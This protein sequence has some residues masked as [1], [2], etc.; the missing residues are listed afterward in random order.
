MTPPKILSAIRDSLNK[1][2][3][4]YFHAV[5][6]SN[7]PF[8]FNL[9]WEYSRG[10]YIEIWLNGDEITINDSH[11]VAMNQFIHGAAEKTIS[12]HD[13]NFEQ[14]LIDFFQYKIPR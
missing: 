1:Q 6:S 7:D 5:A 13:P 9:Q 11:Y 2:R 3:G 4:V 10:N 12:L 14:Q 8:K